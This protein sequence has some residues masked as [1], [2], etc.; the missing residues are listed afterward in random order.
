MRKVTQK[1]VKSF[2]NSENF[3]QGNTR[4][5]TFGNETRLYLHNNLIAKRN[6]K[7]LFITNAGW[8]SNTTKERLNALPNVSIHQKNWEWYLNGKKWNGELTKVD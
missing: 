2:R 5:E 1:A 4:V 8:Q 3:K 6:S 7:G